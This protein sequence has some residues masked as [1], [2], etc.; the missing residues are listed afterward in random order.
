[1]NDIKPQENTK[2]FT[3]TN[4]GN[5]TQDEVVFLCNHCKQ[6][7]LL[8]KEGMYLCPACL[9]PGENFECMNCGSKDV[10]MAKL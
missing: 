1:M 8:Y 3:C 5:I 6:E 9:K 2:L 4:C 7:D 10:K